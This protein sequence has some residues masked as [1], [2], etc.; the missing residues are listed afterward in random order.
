MEDGNSIAEREYGR[1]QIESELYGKISDSERAIAIHDAIVSP[2]NE[3]E[4]AK[5]CE[6]LSENIE[7]F[8]ELFEVVNG[9]Q[10]DFTL[11]NSK[12]IVEKA[13]KLCAEVA[14]F[15]GDDLGV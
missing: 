12:L 8:A 10:S 3:L 1:K 4:T 7:A 6:A 9:D 13:Q 15:V 5:A 2:G 14:E 11:F